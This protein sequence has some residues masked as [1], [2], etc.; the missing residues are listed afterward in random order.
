[1]NKQELIL[2]ASRT[3]RDFFLQNST[4]VRFYADRFIE[5][6]PP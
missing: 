3:R 5:S 2:S 4:I 1:V 6:C